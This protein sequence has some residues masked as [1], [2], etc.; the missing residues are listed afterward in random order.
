MSDKSIWIAKGWVIAGAVSS[1]FVLTG[2][3]Q[4]AAFKLQEQSVRATGRAFSGE[5][6]DTGPESLWWN[7]AAIG[8]MSSSQAYFGITPILPRATS[9]DTGTVVLRPGQSPTGVGG[10]SSQRNPVNDGV[11]PAGGFA[12]PLSDRLAIGLV[13]T[14]PFS[15]TTE[16]AADSWARYG[17]DTTK[18]RTY[19]LQPSI[20]FVPVP[21]LSIGAGLNIEYVRA[22]LSNKLPDPIS[23]LLP[24]AE[25]TLKGNGWDVGYSAGIQY[26]SHLIDLGLSYKSAI[27]HKLTGDFAIAGNQNPVLASIINRSI[28]GVHADFSTPWQLT[29]GARLHVTDRLT[30]NG[31]FTRTGWDKFDAIRLSAPLSTAI[32]ENYKNAN[33]YALGFDYLVSP[34]LTIRGGVQRDLSPI[35]AGYRDPRVP[36]GNRWNFAVGSSYAVSSRFTVDLAASYDKIQSAQIDKIEVAYAGTPLQTVTLTSGQLHN[37]RALVFGVGG[38]WNF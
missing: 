27:K 12:I 35:I 5:V 37:A 33:S 30:I 10:A 6:A 3:A 13:A 2:Q 22:T 20:A 24:D 9:T 31:E 32:P 38:R 8:G 34:K 18:L 25:Q 23:P 7:P 1:A 17:A 21:G 29:A 15:F 16:Y 26:R 4:A 19:D 28:D 14:S 36:D 11:L